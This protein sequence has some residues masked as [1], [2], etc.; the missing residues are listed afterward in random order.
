VA[1]NAANV[2]AISVFNVPRLPAGNA[3]VAPSGGLCAREA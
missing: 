1:F 2:R 3:R